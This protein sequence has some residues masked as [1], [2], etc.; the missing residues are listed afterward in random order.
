MIISDAW[1]AAILNLFVPGAGFLFSRRIPFMLGGALLFM[2]SL[3]PWFSIFTFPSV[4]GMAIIMPAQLT[5]GILEPALGWSFLL[6]SFAYITAKYANSPIDRYDVGIVLAFMGGIVS[7]LI[8]SFQFAYSRL[9]S[10]GA[11]YYLI[12]VAIGLLVI[13]GSLITYKISKVRGGLLVFFA[14]MSF[15]VD[16][17]LILLPMPVGSIIPLYM[18]FALG[19]PW[20]L[21]SLIGGVL[22]LSAKK[23]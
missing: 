8:Q 21:F 10:S 5:M 9:M 15:P 2:V 19:S 16:F 20:L 11:I 12:G 3:H 18:P 13:A 23:G 17:L 22:L 1:K 14:S 6:S 7:T 4:L